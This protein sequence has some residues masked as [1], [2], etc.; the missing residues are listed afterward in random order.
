MGDNGMRWLKLSSIVLVTA[1]STLISRTAMG[2][3]SESLQKLIEVAVKNNS[4]LKSSEARWKMYTGRIKQSSS[5]EDPMIMLKMQNLPLRNPLSFNK[6]T[7]TAK[8][9]GITQQVPFPGK[10]DLKEELAR[11]EAESYR[12]QIEERKLDLVRMVRESYYQLYAVD[13]AM[14]AVGRNLVVVEDLLKI[15]ETRYAVGQGAQAD[16]LRGGVE[17][18]KLLEMQITLQQQRQSLAA[19]L[20]YLLSRPSGSTSVKV[21]DFILPQLAVTRDA[22]REQAYRDRPQIK[23]L[24][25]LLSKGAAGHKLAARES[26]PDFS[27]SFEYMQRE[28]AMNDP[29]YDMY[30]LSLNFNLPVQKER[31]EAM[32]AE[33]MSESRM[34]AEELNTLKSSISY[35]ISDNMAVL[36]RRRKLVE[37]YNTGLIPQAQQSLESSL[38]G[39]RV[40]KVDFLTLLDGRTTLF[41]YERELSDSKAEYMMALARIDALVGGGLP[42]VTPLLGI[43][44]PEQITSG[45]SV[46]PLNGSKH[47]VEVKP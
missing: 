44:Y 39:Y 20:D 11:Y 3:D 8:V 47:D 32:K 38:I 1:I 14:E 46:H 36:E 9:I 26:Y 10:L 31:R 6:D 40:G 30:S 18:S 24:M 33:Y 12:W 21:E 4:E 35:Q 25:S 17:K 41:N 7:T 23:S 22:L 16:I 42:E 19:N 13:K 5:W 15:A 43:S 34:V 29:G 45:E 2:E 28:P 37:L 27:V